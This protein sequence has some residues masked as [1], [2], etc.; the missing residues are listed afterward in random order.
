LNPRRTFQHVRD[1]QSRSLDHS[2]TSPRSGSQISGRV[3][4]GTF[5]ADIGA[6]G[7]SVV[8]LCIGFGFFVGGYLPT[9][10]GASSFS[11]ASLVFGV[12]GAIAGAWAGARVAET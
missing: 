9:L 12:A 11:L 4:R 3:K 8:G 10:W 6:V 2:D 5:R 7:K 1:F